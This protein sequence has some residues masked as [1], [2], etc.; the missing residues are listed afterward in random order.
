[1]MFLQRSDYYQNLELYKI[2]VN[3][4]VRKNDKEHLLE[5]KL[6]LLK[7]VKVYTDSQFSIDR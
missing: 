7:T 3:H 1:M 2:A 4:E 5:K 6:P